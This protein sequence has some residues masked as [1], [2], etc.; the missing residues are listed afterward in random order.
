MNGRSAV[1]VKPPFAAS[2]MPFAAV[3]APIK[4][5]VPV[6]QVVT[7]PSTSD[8]LCAVA[9]TIRMAQMW[10]LFVL[11]M[12]SVEAVWLIG[13]IEVQTSDGLGD[14]ATTSAVSVVAAFV[15][16]AFAV[17]AVPLNWVMFSCH[18]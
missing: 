6:P 16:E 17:A 12:R 1:W 10:S 2:A 13:F 4:A 8:T 5:A 11:V 9:L 14:G 18:G 3:V 7:V 15:P